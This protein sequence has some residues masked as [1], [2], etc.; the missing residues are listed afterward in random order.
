MAHANLNTTNTL[1][2]YS[3]TVYNMK[4]HYQLNNTS[5]P[6]NPV[7]CYIYAYQ[8]S[9]IPTASSSSN[10]PVGT[11]NG[12]YAAYPAI[13]TYG[14]K[15]NTS[16]A[17]PTGAISYRVCN[18]ASSNHST[19]TESSFY[20]LN[21]TSNPRNGV[22]IYYTYAS[23]LSLGSSGAISNSYEY[24]AISY[25][26]CNSATSEL[27]CLINN[28]GYS[29]IYNKP[30]SFYTANLFYNTSSGGTPK[31][32]ASIYSNNGSAGSIYVSTGHTTE[33]YKYALAYPAISTY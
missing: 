22:S 3:S 20:Q 8:S 28:S 33:G 19:G 7:S 12:S 18:C 27:N 31:Y 2:G 30:I 14:I 24:P 6:K 26:A 4:Y 11:G 21:S 32:A 10:V 5:N 17:F 29:N 15:A 25:K 9:Y 13:S 16:K 23:A 1:S